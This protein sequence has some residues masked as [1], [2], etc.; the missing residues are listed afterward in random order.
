MKTNY[1]N[2][3]GIRTS[4]SKSWIS[5]VLSAICNEGTTAPTGLG[6]W[7][8]EIDSPIQFLQL[9][10]LTLSKDG[11]GTIADNRR[12]HEIYNICLVANS[13]TFKTAIRNKGIILLCKFTGA[14]D[15]NVITGEFVTPRGTMQIS[16]TRCR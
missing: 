2:D 1:H 11:S 3:D 15:G 8:I 5:D 4:V 7:E 14:V 6:T 12:V 13:V 16:G 9:T 10:L